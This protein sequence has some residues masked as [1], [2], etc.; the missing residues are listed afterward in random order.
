MT[1]PLHVAQ[2]MGHMSGGGVEQVIMNYYRHIDRS[3]IQFD[4]IV[5]SDSKYIPMEEIKSL[6][7]SIYVV[8]PYKN[9][10]SYIYACEQIFS[11]I[12]PTIVHSNLNSLSVFPLAAAKHA[13]IPIR[14]AHCHTVASPIQSEN[15]KAFIK[16]SL[17]HFS[18]IYPTHLA[19]C[20][21]SA[22][23]WLFGEKTYNSGKVR[24]IKN[25]IDIEKFSFSSQVRKQKREEL[26]IP[27]HQIV[28]GQVGR[29][30]KVKNQLFTV[31]IFAEFLKE[32]PEAVLVIAGDGEL[33]ST[34]EDKVAALGIENNVRLLGMR[35]DIS[36]LYQAFDVL[37]FPSMYEGLG[38]TAIEAQSS[39]LP[40]LS[41]SNLPEDVYVIPELLYPLSLDE[42]ISAWVD[43][44]RKA[45]VYGR[46]KRS[47]KELT[48]R[49][50]LILQN[51][52]YD[53]NKN[54]QALASW[55]LSIAGNNF[56]SM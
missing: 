42:P 16:E 35:T 52:G 30:C 39:G 33:R 1:K 12:K 34:L 14:I 27:P 32:N 36:E 22:G 49:R 45:T 17:K 11:K 3:K 53:I 55:Y 9:L 38:L 40:V 8:P 44:L 51:A 23:E 41:S 47:N 26:G 29:L 48:F 50:K 18:K 46:T 43:N 20:S 6:N 24:I 15:L 56:V 19:A 28:V 10:V 25:A 5:D 2:V 4:F 37:M 54:S 31:K 7:G 21:K 13:Q